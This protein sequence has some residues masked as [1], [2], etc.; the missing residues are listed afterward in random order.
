MKPTVLS[1]CD[2][3]GN[4]VK[5]WAEAG[6]PCVVVDIQHPKGWS[7]LAPNIRAFGG[8][9]LDFAPHRLPDS[10]LPFGMVFAF[11]PCTHLAASG[12]RWWKV[13][14]MRALIDGLTVVD[15]CRH[16][17]EFF[18]Q[19]WMLENPVGRL[20]KCWRE[21]DVSFDPYEYGGYLD[22]EGDAYTK[23][24]CLWVGGGFVMPEPK[25]VYPV[26][27]SKMHRVSP[28][29]G[30]ANIRSETPMGF[31]RAVFEANAPVLLTAN[32]TK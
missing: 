9:V 14:G 16:I 8:D 21:P 24:T 26:E 12:A 1:L 25:P 3:T 11:P 32:V 5:P 19:P 6:F 17:A 7:G 27:G 10:M 29:A 23:K 31:A 18:G 22:P 13:K 20:A 4:M 28:S 2:F 15:R 30:R